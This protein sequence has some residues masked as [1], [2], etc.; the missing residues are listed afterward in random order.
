MSEGHA[1]VAGP[2]KELAS[3]YMPDPIIIFD[4]E[5]RQSLNQL[6]DFEGV[7]DVQ[8]NG[9]IHATL[10]D[11]DRLPDLIAGLVDGGAR[12]TRVEP[13]VPTLEELYFEMQRSHRDLDA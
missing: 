11:L 8:W 13:L 7:I 12:L 3:R 5:N 10:K 9:G 1:R 4:A 2:P 6:A